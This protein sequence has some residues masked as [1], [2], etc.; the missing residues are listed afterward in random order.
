[1]ALACA[2]TLIRVQDLKENEIAAATQN[3]NPTDNVTSQLQTPPITPAAVQCTGGD[4]NIVRNED[5]RTVNERG[6][7]ASRDDNLNLDKFFAQFETEDHED[8]AAEEPVPIEN[9]PLRRSGRHIGQKNHKSM[10][11]GKPSKPAMVTL[12]SECLRMVPIMAFS[13]PRAADIQ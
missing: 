13:T 11:T 1:M 8:I 7:P 5:G 10:H 3:E 2:T 12:P 6:S 9:Q 4:G